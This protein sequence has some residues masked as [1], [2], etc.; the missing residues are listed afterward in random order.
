[1]VVGIVTKVRALAWGVARLLVTCGVAY[2]LWA[3]VFEGRL[4][5][6]LRRYRL[7]MS[8]QPKVALPGGS[9]ADDPYG[10]GTLGNPQG[11]CGTSVVRPAF[12]IISQPIV[13]SCPAPSCR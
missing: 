7:L 10:Q 3:P 4:H 13:V 6:L 9:A 1:M 5:V 2:I 12:R 11:G 8:L